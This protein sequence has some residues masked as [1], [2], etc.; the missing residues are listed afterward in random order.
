MRWVVRWGA[1]VVLS[2]AVFAGVWWACQELAGLDTETA[3]GI[4]GAALAVFLAVAAWWAA[5]GRESAGQAIG[6][7]GA[8]AAYRPSGSLTSPREGARVDRQEPVT[9]MV[10]DLPPGWQPWIVVWAGGEGAYYPRGACQLDRNG[11][12]Q[13]SAVFGR[14]GMADVGGSYEVLLVLADAA[15]STQFRAF[16]G[17]PYQ[18]LPDLP[19]G[20]LKLDQHRVVRR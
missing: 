15:A 8:D 1:V 19:E 6:W 14:A 5:Q 12:F 2:V 4:A 20:A 18:G 3:L 7:R 13:S 10:R 16:V 9:G 11:G 17:P